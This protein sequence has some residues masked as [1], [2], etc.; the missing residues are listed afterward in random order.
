MEVGAVAINRCPQRCQTLALHAQSYLY[1]ELS[2]LVMANIALLVSYSFVLALAQLLFKR[3]A[4]L[5]WQ[6]NPHGMLQ[7]GLGLLSE[8]TFWLA[9]TILVGLMFAW[10]WLIS[11]IPLA[12][13]YP[14]IVLAIVFTG[15]MDRLLFNQP[16][17]WNF[18]VGSGIIV[19]GLIVVAYK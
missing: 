11:F 7:Y 9:G 13:A 5:V 18:F 19:L 15:F 2:R 14:F 1:G 6:D 3:A 8:W 12:K 4:L 16:V 10:G 17:F